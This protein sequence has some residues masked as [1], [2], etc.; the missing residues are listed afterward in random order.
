MEAGTMTPSRFEF[1]STPLSGLTVIQRKPIEDDRGFLCRFYCSED[2]REAGLRKPIAQIN[3]TFTR[4]KGAVRGLHFQYP[5][6]VEAKIVSCLKGEIYDVAV[7]IRRGSPTFLCWYAE[8]L[9][10]DN[11]KSLLIPEGFAHGF[12]TLTAECEIIYLTTASYAPDAEGG[13]SVRDPRIAISWPLG[14]SELSN[15]DKSWAHV[16]DKFEGI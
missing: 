13:L 7:D 12:Q 4:K 2:F 5:P 15:R 3:H 6:H 1:T 9:S 14:I 16:S 8:V 11:T 10:A